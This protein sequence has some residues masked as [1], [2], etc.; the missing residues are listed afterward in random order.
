MAKLIPLYETGIE[1]GWGA[2]TGTTTYAA[3]TGRWSADD[4]QGNH[5]SRPG[6]NF[7]ALVAALGGPP[8]KVEG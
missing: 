4:D 2:G 8:G 5:P 1:I 6:K 3:A 7:S